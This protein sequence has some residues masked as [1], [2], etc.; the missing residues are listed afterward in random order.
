M[1]SFVRSR[2][3]PRSLHP[4]FKEAGRSTLGVQR[5]KARLVRF[6]PAMTYVRHVSVHPR[7]R[8]FCGASSSPRGPFLRGLLSTA[9]FWFDHLIDGVECHRQ[10]FVVSSCTFSAI[11]CLSSR[12]H[13]ST[14]R[15]STRERA[16]C[17]ASRSGL[18]ISPMSALVFPLA[19]HPLIIL[20]TSLLC[21]ISSRFSR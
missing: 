8:C 5:W 1:N 14:Y 15:Q 20:H 10:F 13:I 16:T 2:D 3:R 19:F 17:K 4:H 7:D 9:K 12:V 11:C 18:F 21:R 6:P